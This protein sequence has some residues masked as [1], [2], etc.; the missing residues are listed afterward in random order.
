MSSSN[1]LTASTVRGV[2]LREIV[3]RQRVIPRH[4]H[5]TAGFCLVV[6]GAY[7]ERYAARTLACRARS[8]T[9]SPAGEAHA[10]VFG[11]RAHCLTVDVPAAWIERLESGADR[12]RDPFEVH[13]GALAWIA[14]R[15]L[16]ELH[17]ESTEGGASLI[18][19]G[20]VLELIGEAARSN[21]PARSAAASP[22]I[23]RVREL[24]HAHFR[25]PLSLADLGRAS[26]RHPVYLASAFRRAYG[27]TIGECVRRLRIDH[28]SRALAGTGAPL[29]EIALAAG[30]ANQ[31]HFTRTFK[32]MTGTT[33]GAYRRERSI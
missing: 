22:A 17:Q 8:V 5:D 16:R 3:Y 14:E 19:E 6:D 21:L 32:Q 10:N 23:Q 18:V 26:G 9:F 33:P 31:S 24:V 11:S 20:L 12:F 13:G 30:F 28:A 25:Q 4:T 1:V 29:A 15:L 7:E 2:E 27:E